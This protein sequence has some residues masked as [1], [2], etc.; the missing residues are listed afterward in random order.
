MDLMEH[1]DYEDAALDGGLIPLH[2]LPPVRGLWNTVRPDNT[3]PAAP[4]PDN[5]AVVDSAG[6]PL[7]APA[8]APVQVRGPL[9]HYEFLVRHQ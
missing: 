4:A 1:Q 5:G 6:D 7:S 2:Y 9:Q 8:T 3:L